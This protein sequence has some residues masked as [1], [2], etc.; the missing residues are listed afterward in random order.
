LLGLALVTHTAAQEI[1]V[2]AASDLQFAMLD[3]AARFAQ[4]TGEVR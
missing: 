2:A 4:E 3:I 1:T